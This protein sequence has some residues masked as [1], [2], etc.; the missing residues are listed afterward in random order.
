MSGAGIAGSEELLAEQDPQKA[1]TR[2]L[3]KGILRHRLGVV[4]LVVLVILLFACFGAGWVAPF[5]QGQEDLLFQPCM[6]AVERHDLADLVLG[7][8]FAVGLAG[9]R[10]GHGRAFGIHL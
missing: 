3:L 7:S 10:Q 2:Q 9:R 4:S 6:L 5:P 8:N 1:P